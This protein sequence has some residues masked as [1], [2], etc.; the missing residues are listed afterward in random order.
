MESSPKLLLEFITRLTYNLEGLS[1]ELKLRFSQ[2]LTFH[3]SKHLS[4]SQIQDIENRKAF[5]TFHGDE[6]IIQASTSLSKEDLIWSVAAVQWLQAQASQVDNLTLSRRIESLA[7]RLMTLLQ[8][9]ESVTA[10]A[11][12]RKLIEGEIRAHENLPVIRIPA[13]IW[14]LTLDYVLRWAFLLAWSYLGFEKSS[15]TTINVLLIPAVILTIAYVVSRQHRL[16]NAK[17]LEP[18]GGVFAYKLEF[19]LSTDQYTW[20]ALFLGTSIFIASLLPTG[21]HVAALFGLIPYYF[22]YIRFFRVGKL[23]ENNL[24]KQLDAKREDTRLLSV[25]ENDEAIVGLETKLNSST[26][27]LEAYVLESALFGALSFSGFLQIMATDLVSFV[28]LENFATYIFATA[29]AFIHFDWNSFQH[30]LAQ[31]NNKRILFCL[32]SVESL[33]CSIFFLAVIASRLRFSDI[34]DRVRTALNLAKAYNTKE[35]AF[36]EQ[37][38]ESAA[39]SKRLEAL[40]LKVNE[41]V[42]QANLVLEEINPVMKYMQYFRNGGIFV[43][44]IILISSSL[45]ITGFLS[46]T[47]IFLVLATAAYF[48]KKSLNEKLKSY[49][50]DFRIQFIKQGYW[51]LILTLL[52]GTLAYVLRIF[53]QISVSGGLLALSYFLVGL[54][55]F[56]WLLLAAHVDEQFGEIED[57]ALRLRMSRWKIVKNLMAISLLTYGIGSSFK[58]LHLAGA[59]ELITVSLNLIALLMYFVGYYLTKVRWLGIVVGG[60][61]AVASVGILFKTLHLDGANAMIS[62]AFFAFAIWIPIIIWKRRYFHKLLLRFCLVGFLLTLWYHPFLTLVPL[63][64]E[65]AY[66]H[67]TVKTQKFMD[68]VFQNDFNQMLNDGTTMIDQGIASSD[69]YL[70]TYGTEEGFTVL[71]RI[72]TM[73]YQDYVNEALARS[74]DSPSDS[75][76]LPNALRLARQQHKI[77]LL[78]GYDMPGAFYEPMPVL[79]PVQSEAAVLMAMGRQEEAVQSLKNILAL[80]PPDEVRVPVQE[81]LHKIAKS[82]PMK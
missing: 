62:V 57:K 44:L 6:E 35:E 42:F 3:F 33:V 39:R 45:F 27:R 8:L 15:L 13:K 37:H 66:V 76:L 51:L 77:F 24:A 61:V 9:G 16:A 68:L 49:F 40:T 25:D 78:F 28:D 60:V 32:V 58:Q 50:L 53:L 70:S 12:K 31:L 30:G 10:I 34:A 19:A 71:H 69:W 22:I 11:E 43:F 56:M 18:V 2:F 52:P 75:T 26:S 59:D 47:F 4:I 81:M 80:N 1:S 41:Q 14:P 54:Y 65:T 48:N 82:A 79:R 7:Q 17:L 46:W 5:K 74:K 29:Q 38:I 72:L 36:H 64:L 67:K 21:L 55:L 73:Q 63:R 20:L 23:D